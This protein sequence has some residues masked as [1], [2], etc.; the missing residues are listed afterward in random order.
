MPSDSTSQNSIPPVSEFAGFTRPT[1]NTTYTP[2]QF[3]DVCLPHC[4][5]GCI[6]VVAL[7]IRLTL[8]WSD[9]EGNPQRVQHL[10]TYEDF[11]RAGISRSMIRPALQ[12]AIQGPFVRCVREPHQRRRGQEAVSGVYELNW[13]ERPGYVKD[14]RQFRGFF[15]GEGNRTYI[16]NQ[17]F[18]IVI[19][20]ETLAV[21]KV[22]GSVI[23]FSIVFQNKWGHRLKKVALSYQH[24]QN[25]SRIA[26]RNTLS[27]AIRHALE[28]N[29][30]RLVEPGQFDPNA[31]KTSKAAVYA[32]K[33][34]YGEAD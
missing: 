27:A 24:I 29:Y 5:R 7:M 22:V 34:L 8:G 30:I 6:R 9:E 26:N 15:A 16:P 3:F 33:W 14:P 10:A 2:N 23:R 12:E 20:K 32:I 18:D 19:R 25:Y 31:G 21:V 4:S 17:F 13:D 1:S 11:Q 28:S